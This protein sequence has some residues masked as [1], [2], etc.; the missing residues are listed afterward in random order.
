ME[1]SR[2]IKKNE[3]G[4][5]L[6]KLVFLHF[7]DIVTSKHLC[8]LCFKR[9]EILV[10][11][12]PAESTRLLREGDEI[13]LQI[14]KSALE[15]DRLGMSVTLNFEDEYLAIVTKDAGVHMKGLKEGLSFALN[16]GVKIDSCEYTCINQ[17]PRAVNG[18]IIVSKTMDIRNKLAKMLKLEEI[19]QRYRVI[20]HG[21]YEYSTSPNPNFE[22]HQ[23]HLTRSTSGEGNYLTTLDVVINSCSETLASDIKKYFAKICHHI[24]GSNSCSKELKSCKDKGMMMALVEISLQHPVMEKRIIVKIEEPPKFETIRQ[25]ELRFYN[26]KRKEEIEELDRYGIKFSENHDSQIPIAYTT[27]EKEF[28]D[29]RF[30]VTKDTMIP[31]SSTEFL[32][33]AALNVF[34]ESDKFDFHNVKDNHGNQ[35]FAILDIGTG[36]GSILI[37]VLHSIITYFYRMTPNVPLNPLIFGIGLDI[38]INTLDV[39]RRNAARHLDPLV[40]RSENLGEI[41]K[42]DFIHADMSNLHNFIPLFNKDFN[43]L[44]CN[45]PYLD[46]S[47]DLHKDDKRLLEP[48]E[49]LFADE[50]GFKAYR[51][52]FETLELSFTEGK[53]ILRKDASVIVEVGSKMAEKV[54]KIF[55]GWNCVRSINDRQGFERCLIFRRYNGDSGLISNLE[56]AERKYIENAL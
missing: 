43:V 30:Y 55:K 31:R 19:K 40:N 5:R 18:L 24:V 12:K 32:V 49:A 15:K 23:V 13:R 20:V 35:S 6:E 25:R 26:K 28:F 16:N 53:N 4:I 3:A 46:N 36:S 33:H 1:S 56:E 37:S 51:L 42:Y 29:L 41:L 50:D 7:R 22:V 27:G 11:G 17:L 34:H 2:I 14:N 39:A 8:R 38:N 52:L 47:K 48:R 9:G 21:K 44:V 10:N 54:K 45:P